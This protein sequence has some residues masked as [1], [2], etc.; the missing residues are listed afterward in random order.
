MMLQGKHYAIDEECDSPKK[1]KLKEH[2]VSEVCYEFC[3]VI[4]CTS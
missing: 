1:N 2:S 4:V 3:L